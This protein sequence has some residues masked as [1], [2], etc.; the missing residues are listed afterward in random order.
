MIFIEHKEIDIVSM[1]VYIINY[2]EAKT[3]SIFN[4]NSKAF[5]IIELIVVVAILGVL[6][7]LAGPRLLGYV[8]KAELARIQHDVKVMENKM[9]EILN[10][11]N[12]FDE[13]QNNSKDLGR[14]VMRKELYEK[15]GVVKSINWEHLSA[16]WLRANN[17]D[18][19]NELGMGGDLIEL[20]DKYSTYKIIPKEYSN[21]INTKL[22]G[23]FYVNSLGKVYYEHDKSLERA[24]EKEVLAC[25]APSTLGYEFEIADG[26]G[27]ITGWSGNATHLVIPASFK[28]SEGGKEWCEPVRVIGAGAFQNGNFKKVTIPQSVEEIQDEAFQ[29]GELTEIEIPHSVEIVGDNAFT[30]NPAT[31]SGGSGGSGGS[32]SESIIVKGSSDPS[33]GRNISDSAFGDLE[34]NYSPVTDKDLGVITKINNNNNEKTVSIV[35]KTVTSDSSSSNS[36]DYS[37]TVINIPKEIE[38]DGELLPITEIEKGAFQGSGLIDVIM[39]EGLLYIHDYAFAG[40]QLIRAVIPNSVIEVGNYAFAYN[41]IA[42]EPTI[43]P[44]N[45]LEIKFDGSFKD[46]NN[47]GNISQPVSNIDLK[48][49]IFIISSMGN[50]VIEDIGANPEQPDDN[51]EEDSNDEDNNKEGL[52]NPI[53]PREPIEGEI[54]INSADD[55][56]KIRQSLNGKYILTSDIDLSGIDWTPIGNNDSRFTG[57]FN[58]NGY[59]ITGL[60]I[61]KPTTENVGLFG[62]IEGA[63]IENVALEDIDITGGSNTGGL[64]G[65]AYKSSITNSYATGLITNTGDYTGGLVGSAWNGTIENSYATGSVTGTRGVGGIVGE[66]YSSTT[67]T[68]SYATGSVTGTWNTG[69]LVGEAYA[70]TIENSYAKGEVTGSVTG[71]GNT[72]GLVGK[73]EDATVTNSYATGSVSGR[74]LTGGLVGYVHYKNLGS[75]ITNSYATGEVSGTERTGGLV[76]YVYYS[77]ITNSYATGSV[78]GSGSSTGG[79][80]GWA[81]GSSVTNSYATGSVTGAGD[82]GGLVGEASG[83]SVTNSYWDT[84]TTGQSSSA[85]GGL[86]KTTKEMKMQDTYEGWDFDEI[87]QIDEG[88]YPTL[89]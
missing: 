19:D 10:T 64:V 31:S 14:V 16:K 15:Q 37:N 44:I 54:A 61:N 81:S 80:V 77:S 36:K 59:S 68:N 43:G 63:T 71:K 88:S 47:E 65:Y 85:R 84:E 9:A 86:G 42:S 39:P 69:G 4:K 2:K 7:M 32:D 56:N 13:W 74:N 78:T 8:E 76:G 55:F 27:T 51:N 30:D 45:I 3:M 34:P 79:L 50:H 22:K 11:N 48:D 75:S 21:K 70:S 41:E 29:D 6:I 40:N 87:W 26:L 23:T 1:E 35:G 5:T 53:E 66:A 62:V 46:V 38:V 89:R 12:S 58:G 82:A 28:M 25:V 72:G 57:S 83:S 60:K 49:H 33:D 20:D 67:I 52:M 73:T 18:K 24:I 17:K